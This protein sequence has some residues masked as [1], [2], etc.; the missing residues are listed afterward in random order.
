MRKETYAA[1]TLGRF[2]ARNK[3]A[4]MEQ[5]KKLLGTDAN[6]TVIRKLKEL[7]YLSSYSHRGKYYTLDSIAEFDERGLWSFRTA[8]FSKESAG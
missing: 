6:M 5:L 8:M 1:D 4:T 3:I 2:F 7:S